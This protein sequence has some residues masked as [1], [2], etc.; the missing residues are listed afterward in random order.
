[1]PREVLERN[2]GRTL[3]GDDPVAYE[4]G[5][6]GHPEKVYQQLVERCGLG[7]DARVLE[8][9]PGTGQV[10]RR[11]LELGACRIVAVEPDERLA[12]YL[13]E[14][15]QK[16]EVVVAPLEEAALETEAFDLA[17]A[18]SAFHWVDEARGLTVV[19]HALRPGGWWA[20]WWTLFGEGERK[21]DFMRSVDH[22]FVDLA[23]SPSSGREG[24]PPFALDID[25]RLAG[26]EAA[27]FVDLR[28]ELVRWTVTWDTPRI[29]ALYSTFSPIRRLDE[30]RRE[31][32][33]DE[34]ALIATRDFGGQVSR[35]LVTSLYTA[36]RP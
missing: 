2:E 29:R 16:V 9:G 4:T 27:G 28:H 6:P 11:L 30:D 34:V 5:R 7:E 26:L 13:R 20:M 32:L 24:G 33:L 35:T 14:R 19:R 22:L 10:T 1:M 36:R 15:F 25:D 17:V 23:R 31:A 18:A 21:D 12:A 3:F 8:I